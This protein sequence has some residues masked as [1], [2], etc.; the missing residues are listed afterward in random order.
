MCAHS[1]NTTTHSAASTGEK[2]DIKSYITCTD[3]YVIYSIRCKICPTI[4]YVGQTTQ[5]ASERFYNHRS[6]VINKKIFK[7]VPNH[8][9]KSKHSASDMIFLPF[10][11]L[12][13]EDKTLLDVRERYWINMKK[14]LQFGLN[15][16]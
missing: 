8:F 3:R 9:C 5:M 2:F 1:T 16:C 12:P 10:E 13:Q 7:P 14:T 4:E 6:D 11:K 15:S